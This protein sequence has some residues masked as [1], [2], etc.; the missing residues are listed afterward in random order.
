MKKINKLKAQI[1]ALKTKL[2]EILYND[3]QTHSKNPKCFALHKKIENLEK[4][5]AKEIELFNIKIE[6]D[7]WEKFASY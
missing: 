5:L 2:S 3:L 4:E 7:Y 1:K 6:N